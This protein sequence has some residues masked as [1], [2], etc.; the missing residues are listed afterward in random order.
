MIL[1]KFYAVILL[2]FLAAL[3]TP[4]F[5]NTSSMDNLFVEGDEWIYTMTYINKTTGGEEAYLVYAV[6]TDNGHIIRYEIY[7]H[8]N[9]KPLEVIE[10]KLVNGILV[11]EIAYIY[12]NT[13]DVI[14][15]KYTN[16]P[17]PLVIYP[18]GVGEHGS[19]ESNVDI[20]YNGEYYTS[21]IEKFTYQVAGLSKVERFNITI[22]AFMVVGNY[23]MIDPETGAS[24]YTSSFIYWINA[25]FKLPLVQIYEDYESKIIY[26]M[27]YY[28]ITPNPLSEGATPAKPEKYTLIIDWDS[29]GNFSIGVPDAMITLSNASG[30]IAQIKIR[31]L[32]VTL[33]LDAGEYIIEINPVEGATIDSLGR[34]RFL[35]WKVGN[36]SIPSR[37]FQFT[38]RANITL[39]VAFEVYTIQAKTTTTTTA[40]TTKSTETTIT[41]KTHTTTTTA[42]TTENTKQPTTSTQTAG[43]QP[44]PSTSPSATTHYTPSTRSGEVS[45]EEVRQTQPSYVY[46]NTSRQEGENLNVYIVAAGIVGAAGAGVGAYILASRK[47]KT[48]YYSEGLHQPMQAST[49]PSQF[50]QNSMPGAYPRSRL[51]AQPSSTKRPPS[52]APARKV[53]PSCGANLPAIARFCTK[54]GARV[55]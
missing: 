6:T 2:M 16:N 1:E 3:T 51:A 11:S 40:T 45:G 42:T 50:Q 20:Y 19:Y 22:D 55:S 34:F 36:Q 38:L 43:G 49:P 54:C 31:D 37:L 17:P 44:S 46:S 21:I 9:P 32:P 48:R 39:I 5:V 10:Y 24:Y 18:E 15:Y 7:E 30:V 13:N 53:C 52:T 14:V 28:N 26:E 33:D 41:T 35:E 8:D 47:R 27:N 29:S 25:S 12:P 23:S 4:F